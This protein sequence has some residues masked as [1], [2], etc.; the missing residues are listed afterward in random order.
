MLT[1]Q[2]LTHFKEYD[3]NYKNFDSILRFLVILTTNNGSCFYL[4]VFYEA[5][6]SW[7]SFGSL[8]W[9]L[10]THSK[11]FLKLVYSPRH[12]WRT[13]VARWQFSPSLYWEMAFPK[14]CAR[15]PSPVGIGLVRKFNGENQTEC[16]G[17]YRAFRL[18]NNPGGTLLAIAHTVLSDI[19]R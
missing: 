13:T 7:A 12:S 15:P 17:K 16:V 6:P 14:I 1:S 3:R 11:L 4:L 18:S 19:V 5:P 8:S 10:L 9:I 2:S